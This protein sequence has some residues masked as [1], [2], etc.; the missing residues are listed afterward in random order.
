MTTQTL[1]RSFPEIGLE[2]PSG[3]LADEAFAFAQKH[4]QETFTNHVVR[5]A[6][7][8]VI[9]AKKLPA[10]SS[11][12]VDLEAVIVICLL[13]DMGLVATIDNNSLPGLTVDRRFE[14]DGANIARDFVRA[15]GARAAHAAGDDDEKKKK[16][17]EWDE[18]RLERLWT[19][20]SLHTTPSIARHA[21]PEVAL[22]QMAVEADFFGPFWTPSG[23]ATTQEA[24][25][26][27]PEYRAVTSLY[28]RAEFTR[29]GVKETM[30]GLC[31]RKP[32]TTYDNFTS[33]FGRDFGYDGKGTGKEEYSEKWEAHQAA[34]FLL[35]GLDALDSLEKS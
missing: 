13:H 3:P 25:I 23:D 27:V 29:Q 31:Q 12:D 19:A 32:S 14:V 21:A 1:S 5:C 33:L 28:P 26:T 17:S 15:Y 9:L 11:Q 16:E 10:F 34:G 8:A 35:Q 6:Y 24:P 20:I 22:V 18:A 30:C 4:C 7:W 2:F